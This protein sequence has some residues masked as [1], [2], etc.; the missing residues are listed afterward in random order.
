MGMESGNALAGADTRGVGLVSMLGGAGF[1]L[2]GALGAVA[3]WSWLFV[4]VGF[5]SLLYAMP[6]LHRLQAPADGPMG[7]WGSRL[8]VFGASIILALGVIFLVWDAVGDPGEPAWVEL[9]WPIGFFSALIGFILFMIGS[10]KARVLDQI[11]LRLVALGL[12]GGVVLD[13][14]TGAFFEDNGDTTDWG[15]YLGI[16]LAGL[17]LLWL[18][19]QLR[20]RRQAG[21]KAV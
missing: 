18:G 14:A 2:G 19:Y 12:V 6:G 7:N 3:E 17:G 8:Y 11:G 5:A 16:P 1:V 13:M 20:A 21:S 15:L 4:L 9:V 10:L